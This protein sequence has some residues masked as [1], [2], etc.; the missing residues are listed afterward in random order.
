MG[1]LRVIFDRAG[2]AG[3]EAK[4]AGRNLLTYLLSGMYG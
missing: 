4:E 3:E 2:E 1:E